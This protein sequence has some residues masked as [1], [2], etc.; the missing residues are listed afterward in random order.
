MDDLRVQP[1]NLDAEQ[2]VIGSVLLDPRCIPEVIE[3]LSAEDFYSQVHKDIYDTVY[4]MFAAGDTIDPVT[5]LNEMR[6]RKVYRDPESRNYFESLIKNTPTAAHV[7]SYAAIVKEFSVKRQLNDAAAAVIT[8]VAEPQSQSQI[9]IDAAEQL[10][11]NIRKDRLS[12]SMSNIPEVLVDVMQ[13]IKALADS[14]NRIPGISSGISDL[15]RMIGGLIDSNFILIASRPGVGKTSFALNITSY[16]A[17]HAGKSIVF[18]SLEM[19][20]Q[21][22]ATRMLSSAARVDSDLLLSAALTDNDWSKLS[23]AASRLARLPIYFDDNPAITVAEMKA[24]CRRIQNLGLIVVDYLQLMQGASGK[25]YD[26]RTTEV[27]DIS[28]SLKIMAKELNVPV[29]CLSQL[30]RD[31]E[32]RGGNTVKLSDI[33]ESGAIEQDADVVMFLQRG[34]K[35]TP[36]TLAENEVE[37]T[38]AKNR[39]GKTGSIVLQW[40]GQYTSLSEK[41]WRNYDE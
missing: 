27:A 13:N 32:K 39:H 25:R 20:R 22:L 8:M 24:K 6:V 26:N 29:L 28:R 4:S 14:G 2:S 38:V 30:S 34:S 7:K 10:F 9:V 19:S 21:Q 1:H 37:V 36:E 33:R 15:D 18:F 17:S 3:L 31:I 35:E 11:F 16:A 23:E 5:I 40:E 41:E 12:S